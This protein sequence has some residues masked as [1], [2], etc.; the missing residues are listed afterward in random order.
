MLEP[1]THSIFNLQTVRESTMISARS[2]ACPQGLL[3]SGIRELIR[4]STAHGHVFLL[5]LNTNAERRLTAAWRYCSSYIK[6]LQL[7]LLSI[8]QSWK[9]N[10][11]SVKFHL[12]SLPVYSSIS[13]TYQIKVKMGKYTEKTWKKVLQDAPN[14][15]FILFIPS[16]FILF[17]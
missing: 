2:E 8:Y 4:T 14:F 7:L 10:H 16:P 15:I 17:F 6:A 11:Q 9:K 3:G 1:G 5:Q 13:Q 12:K